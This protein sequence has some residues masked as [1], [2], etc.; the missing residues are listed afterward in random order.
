MSPRPCPG[1][2]AEQ[3]S[4]ADVAELV[5]QLESLV[6][7]PVAALRLASRGEEAVAPLLQYLLTGRIPSVF[8]PRL[9]AVEAEIDYAGR[10]PRPITLPRAAEP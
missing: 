6:D 5:S 4:C 7:G 9:W 1:A 8:Q 10:P 3:G 2:A